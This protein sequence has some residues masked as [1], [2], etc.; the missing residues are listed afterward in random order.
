MKRRDLEAL[1]DMWT[2]RALAAIAE[3]RE[4]TPGEHTGTVDLYVYVTEADFEEA[5]GEAR[6][7]V[8]WVTHSLLMG[9][10]VVRL[11][12]LGYEARLV[13]FTGAL[14]EPTNIHEPTAKERMEK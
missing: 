8:G 1:A 12:D 6:Y 13:P 14:G 11:R 10:V 7:G 3:V 5:G 9:N 2:E 4:A